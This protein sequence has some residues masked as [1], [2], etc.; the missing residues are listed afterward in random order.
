MNIRFKLLLLAIGSQMLMGLAIVLYFVILSP[1]EQLQGE[2]AYFQA[3][4]RKAT[5][6]QLEMNKLATQGIET[7]FTVFEAAYKDYNAAVDDMAKI[8]ALPK[9]NETMQN[10]VEAIP[11]LREL[12]SANLDSIKLTIDDLKNDI[13]AM[14]SP[15]TDL[16][17]ATIIVKGSAADL[18]QSFGAIVQYHVNSMMSNLRNANDSLAMTVKVIEEKDGIVASEIATITTQSTLIATGILVVVLIGVLVLSV[19]MATNIARALHKLS[20]T[21]EVMGTG[22]LTCRFGLKR[23]DEIGHLGQDLDTLLE[24][25]NKSLQQ[26]QVSSNQ[27]KEMREDLV[28]IVAESS[29][30][31]VEIEA[32]SESI[33]SQMVRMDRMLESAV[34]E[35]GGMVASI[36]GF[37][38][39][40][41]IQNHHVSG[42][43]AAV[44]QMLASIEN[45]DRITERDRQSAE[46]LVA[47]SDQSKEIF[48]N[49]FEK[50]A[51]ITDSVSAIQEMASVIAGIANQTN[52]LAMNAA[53]EAAHAGEFGKGFA[54][55]ADEIGKLAT[56]S[57]LSSDEI[58]HTIAGIVVKMNEA[59]ATRETT[60]RAFSNISAKIREVSESI[61]EIYSNVNEMQSG[62][63]QILHAM[64]SL[65]STSSQITDESAQIEKT[66]QVISGT[67][68]DLG[69]ISHEVT[70]NIT[71]IATGVQLIS[72]S[73]RNVSGHTEQMRNIG[74]DLDSAVSA[75]KTNGGEAADGTPA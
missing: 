8:V 16:D 15:V 22:D 65:R 35:I 2:N 70:A 21:V 64:E 5:I 18:E 67:M 25:L 39:R 31:A 23:K 52:I 38:E 19:L 46:E 28:R 40:L 69:R 43:V 63:K 51:E 60:T 50:V 54:V 7:Q 24:N 14:K 49:A 41:G 66:T 1:I 45:I 9:I 30:S 36:N 12:S 3:A 10:A 6:L 47:E 32:N 58:A 53:I 4:A 44:T 26:I 75:F 61:A 57:A 20:G 34:Q 48:E 68:G 62:S 11:K 29:N 27:N 71:E 74:Q 59:G 73:V 37:H 33:R 55:V 72:A 42:T 17:I 13:A 56:A